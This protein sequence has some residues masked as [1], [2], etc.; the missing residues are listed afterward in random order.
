ML[1]PWLVE[2]LEQS[3]RKESSP[4]PRLELPLPP[5]EYLESRKPKKQ[6]EAPRGV[7]V[8]NFQID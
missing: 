2:K 5:P 4:Q 8:I 3:K 6:E 1:A 7:T